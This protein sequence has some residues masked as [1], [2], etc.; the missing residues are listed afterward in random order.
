MG[1]APQARLPHIFEPE[2]PAAPGKVLET[3]RQMFS[4]R[5]GDNQNPYSWDFD[6]CSLTLGNFNYRKMTLVR[7]YTKLIET[8]MASSAFD[9]VFSLA[10]KPPEEVTPPLELAD[11]H[12]II[13][14][15]AAQASAISR[16]RTGTSYIIQGPPGT[17]KSQTITN[18]IADYVARGQRVLFVCEKRAAIDVVFHR[19]RR[20][21]LHLLC[22]LIH[23]SQEDKKEFIMDL[24]QTYES[25]VEQAG[26]KGQSSGRQRGQLLQ[27]LQSELKPLQDFYD[28]MGAPAAGSSIPLRQLLERLVTLRARIPALSNLD[29]E[30][31]PFYTQWC[32]HHERIERLANLLKDM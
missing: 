3:E 6:L 8:D 27:L 2:A 25:F 23:D 18:L 30:R 5:D 1:G 9:A 24:K 21:G 16:A 26:K 19:L 20:N 32:D 31:L 13:S 15:D 4:L 10:P 12:L 29:K 28:A 22:S 14:C 7:D 17:G 11:Q